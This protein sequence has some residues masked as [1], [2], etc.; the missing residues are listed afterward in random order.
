MNKKVILLSLFLIIIFTLSSCKKEEVFHLENP[1]FTNNEVNSLEDLSNIDFMISTIE[2][3]YYDTYF[4]GFRDFN[5]TSYF[6]D[7]PTYIDID[8]D[9]T[10]YRY[11][12]LNY[13]IEKDNYILRDALIDPNN[14]SL[15]TA[16]SFMK[17]ACPNLK[18]GELCE[19][20]YTFYIEE[21]NYYIKETRLLQRE[22]LDYVFLDI[23]GES[24]YIFQLKHYDEHNKMDSH[25]KCTLTEDKQYEE[26]L[27]DLTSSHIDRYKLHNFETK[28]IIYYGFDDLIIYLEETNEIIWTDKDIS[29]IEYQQLVRNVTLV[30]FDNTLEH[31]TINLSEF[32]GWDRLVEIED[33]PNNSDKR[34]YKLYNGDTLLFDEVTSNMLGSVL[35]TIENN[36]FNNESELLLDGTGITTPYD[37]NFINQKLTMS[38]QLAK[39]IIGK[40]N[41]YLSE[42]EFHNYLLNKLN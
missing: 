37:Y 5:S 32:R 13:H 15:L 29:K 10:I 23:H 40:Y 30:S 1:F 27:L 3:Y 21:D 17:E 31:F 2:D 35:Y 16:Y 34:Y 4:S 12:F 39:D 8:F 24:Q 11:E 20:R 26:I 22:E 36:N 42:E 33:A 7:E 19:N 25:L 18:E 41:F 9:K 14:E 6:Q 38:E 28:E